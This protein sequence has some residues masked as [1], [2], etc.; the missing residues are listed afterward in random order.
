MD[1]RLR[2]HIAEYA[3]EQNPRYASIVT[4]MVDFSCLSDDL[5]YG[6][7]IG[8]VIF[9]SVDHVP[10][11]T[12]YKSPSQIKFVN[13]EDMFKGDELVFIQADTLS[14]INND[15]DHFLDLNP[16]R[17]DRVKEAISF[18]EID[19]PMVHLRRHDESSFE[20]AQGRHRIIAMYKYNIKKIDILVPADE[21]DKISLLL[22]KQFHRPPVTKCF[23]EP[24]TFTLQD[25]INKND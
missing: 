5:G 2:E 4:D 25:F 10:P 16:A 14:L 6:H 21:A 13:T 20:V 15:H 24:K 9:P 18:G 7:R 23:T 19:A 3:P 17:Y 11:C 8:K 22:K 1:T 12:K